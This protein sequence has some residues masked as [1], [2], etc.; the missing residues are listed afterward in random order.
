MEVRAS[1]KETNN[2]GHISFST[3]HQTY[4]S[5]NALFNNWNEGHWNEGHW[6]TENDPPTFRKFK[7]KSSS[8]PFGQRIAY[9][10]VKGSIYATA[11]ILVQQVAYALSDIIFSSSL[12]SFDLDV[13]VKDWAASNVRNTNNNVPKIIPMQ[14][15]SGAGAI[16]LGYIVSKKLE[17]EKNLPPQSFLTYCSCLRN[18]R[19]FL[20]QLT[21]SHS[22]G[23]P[24]VSHAAAIGH[25]ADG[26]KSF[27]TDYATALN[28]SRDLGLGLVSSSNPSEAQHMAL[29]STVLANVLPTIHI[30]DGINM[31]RDTLRVIDALNASVL[32]DTYNNASVELSK[33]GRRISA[34]TKANHLL[35]AINC[36]LGTAYNLFEYKGH[37]APETV[38][39]VFGS[40]ESSL[41]GQVAEKL[42]AEG[43]KVGV[44]S[45]RVYSPFSEEAFANALPKSVRT[46]AVLG[47]VLNQAAV[48][49]ASVNSSLYE[50]IL[51]AIVLSNRWTKAPSVVDLKYARGEKFTPTSIAAYF[52]KSIGK[53]E[54]A[55]VLQL[56][57][58]EVE[59]YIFFDLP[60][61]AAS[62]APLVIGKLLSINSLNHVVISQTYNIS[63]QSGTVRTDIRCSKKS[64]ETFYPVEMA[65]VVYVGNEKL[66]K[67]IDI[68]ENIKFRGK[69]ILMLPGV[70]EYFIDQRVP[71]L[72]R[73]EIKSKDLQV[74]I[75]DPSLSTAAQRD[76]AV[77]TMVVEL[78]FLE[79]TRPDLA[80]HSYEKLAS[81]NGNTRI[82]QE[83]SADLDKIIHLFPVPEDWNQLRIDEKE[84][85]L[86][87]TITPSS[88]AGLV[89]ETA[90]P[91]LL[92][93]D[94]QSIARCFVFKEAYA[95]KYGLRPDFSR[96]TCEIIL[97]RKHQLTLSTQNQKF[98]HIE[99]DLGESGLT[100]NVGDVLCI[101]AEN[102]IKEVTN[103]ITSYG[104]NADDIFEIPYHEDDNFLEVQTV[105][106]FLVRSI[107]IF[108]KPTKEFYESLSRFAFDKDEKKRLMA[109]G[110]SDE[111][112][113]F[114]R[115][116]DLE[117]VTYA[118]ILLEFK[119]THP[120]FRDIIQMIP[121]IE[122]RKYLIAS[123]LM[124]DPK[125][126][127]IL[128]SVD[129]WTDSRGRNRYGQ[130]T[131]YLS[132]ISIGTKVVVSVE[133]SRVK[134]P[135]ADTT[136]IIMSG[137]GTGVAPFRAFVQDRAL[138]KLQGKAIGPVLIYVGSRSSSQDYLFGEEWEAYAEAGVITLLGRPFSH[139]HPQKRSIQDSMRETIGEIIHAYLREEGVFYYCGSPVPLMDIIG[140]IKEAITREST[141]IG[142]EIDPSEEFER[143]KEE[144]RFMIE[145]Y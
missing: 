9:T 117:N 65:D 35:Y 48:A 91:S 113:E 110:G 32:R 100:Y 72:V 85:E 123:S 50:E 40:V 5:D 109:L 104:L 116:A 127:S 26:S 68:I 83:V 78:A 129:S 43:S 2:E 8:L 92:A 29:Y 111:A 10:S 14:A 60:S 98:F 18:Y 47:Q 101:H 27:V 80:D 106:Q 42:S 88:F 23:T 76:K 70:E 93:F 95:I 51:A 142:A 13:S 137:Y 33:L 114:R 141:A 84:D 140:V 135:A 15:S 30:Y 46:I 102:N 112:S 49:D 16:P 20:D 138:K 39:V 96:N 81:I 120:S 87:R 90:E 103:F 64:I 74:F 130:A 118:D 79:A 4:V 44:V 105:Y 75:L 61:T 82:F 73:K 17:G 38:L 115:R 136:P 6:N 34:S 11:Q 144:S 121:Q 37:G 22:A 122:C 31:G 57:D 66:L 67:D 89:K 62:T 52:P 107:D 7:Q 94:R 131:R 54:G 19:C 128:V 55:K 1:A 86:P 139:N 133:P 53:N 21:S 59:Q 134:L 99:F 56:V 41:A 63:N 132:E 124:T 45:V 25:E 3:W 28:I 58:S 71:D 77:E 145:V 12:E 143:L 36:E 24:F 126:I 119:C 108:G 69:L 125:I 97:Q